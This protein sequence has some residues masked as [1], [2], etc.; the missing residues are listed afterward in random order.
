M[1]G[2][3]RGSPSSRGPK[4]SRVSRSRRFRLVPPAVTPLDAGDLAAGVLAHLRGR[5]R[6]A[7]RADVAAMLGASSTATYTSFRRALG[8]GLL[9]LASDTDREVVLVP[10]FC[11][12][13]YRHAIEGVGLTVQHYDVDPGTFAADLDSFASGLSE[14]VLAAVAVNVF[15]YSSPMDAVADLCG[16]H[17]VP[18]VEALGYAIGGVYR[19]DP[20][21]TFG[22]CAVLNFQQG[23]PIPVGGGMVASRTA[24]VAVADAGRP[25]VAPNVGTLAGYAVFA[26]P[27]GYAV[28]EAISGLLERYDLLDDHLT[29]HPGSKLSVAYDRPF[30]TMSDFQGAIG[31]RVLARLE[32]DQGRRARTADS[33]AEALAGVEGVELVRPVD[34]LERHQHVRYPVVA[35]SP[36]VR[37]EMLGALRAVGVHATRLYDWPAVAEDEFPGAARLQRGTLALP[38]HPYVSDE[39]RR[40]VVETVRAVA[41]ESGR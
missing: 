27:R 23:K 32:D 16:D 5:G 19:G 24:S 31:R 9:E 18:L 10:A 39:D 12:T 34:G 17:G 29:T 40:T 2:E 25:A 21:G 37:D 33:Y 35:D 38:T 1:A 13:D 36:S 7:F 28:F 6:E 22:D 30:E 14:N 15:G 41:S 3:L 20:L 11:S 4:R 8:A 26:D